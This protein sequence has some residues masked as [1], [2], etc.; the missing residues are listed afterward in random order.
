ML[1]EIGFRVESTN[2][3]S[4]TLLVFLVILELFVQFYDADDLPSSFN[5]IDMIK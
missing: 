2:W 1:L 4:L 3:F 5:A